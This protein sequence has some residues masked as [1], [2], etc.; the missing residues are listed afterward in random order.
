MSHGD[1]NYEEG[2]YYRQEPRPAA[3]EP[4]LSRRTLLWISGGLAAVLLAMCACML[5]AGAFFLGRQTAQPA[6]TEVAPE[7]VPGGE[8][9]ETA[10]QLPQAVITA[11]TETQVG[12]PVEFDGSGSLAGGGP[13][14]RYE[15]QFGD[16]ATGEGAQTSYA[17]TAP[18][19]Y[20]V[21][22]TVTDEQEQTNSSEPHQIVVGEGAAAPSA[23]PTINSFAVNPGQIAAGECVDLIW[24]VSADAV[25][26]LLLRDGAPLVEDLS[27]VGQI[28]DCPEVVGVSLYRLEAYS[29]DSL[30]ASQEQPV[31]IVAGETAPAQ[32]PLAG[33]S[34]RVKT[35][36]MSQA[37]LPDT[38]I[39]LLFGGDGIVSG[40]GG[41]NDYSGGYTASGNTLSITGLATAGG[42]CSA[43]VDTQEQTYLSLLGSV[44]AFQT[45]GTQLSLADGTGNEVLRLE[46]S[47][48]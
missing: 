26:V 30:M 39:T 40:H 1:S 38:P 4:F 7:A 24:D 33:T 23:A 42:T 27:P 18:G 2:P 12:Q 29:S 41:C 19:S 8:P 5:L 11:P 20:E 6:A 10:G 34:W 46:A 21:V 48:Q 17:Y 31:T 32:N 43:E 13:I 14:T 36:Q 35:L 9:T 15:W 44:A 3:P 37:P 16:G 28:Q 45:T 47:G 25:R 22:L